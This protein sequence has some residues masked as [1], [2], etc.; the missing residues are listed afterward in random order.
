[1][2]TE[3]E[4]MRLTAEELR[5]RAAA[6]A[7]VIVPVAS[8]EQHGPHLAT[9]VDIVLGTGVAQATAARIAAAGAPVVVTPCVWTGL[10]EHHMEFGGTVT[11][12]YAAMAAVLGGIV[13]S[14]ARHGFKRVM[15]LN[16]HGGNAEAVIQAASE[17][18]IALGIKVAA[19][20]YWHI[21]PE[22]I[23]PILDRQPGLMHACEAET[24][25]MLALRPDSVRLDR[26]PEA[27]GP[28]S[29][30]VEGQPA[31]LALRRSFRAISETGVIGDA[32]TASAEK[33]EKLLAAI[34]G[35]LAELLLNPTLWA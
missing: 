1:M 33:G 4:W 24:S 29:T 2:A 25:L 6:G 19:G 12:D 30:R 35:R 21:V 5:A 10:A 26:L 11:L 22:V 17:L 14:A 15:L 32:R 34:S 7:L 8:L 31:G 28:M 13:R 20:T 16:G 9:G 23:A 18:T 27:H 3:T